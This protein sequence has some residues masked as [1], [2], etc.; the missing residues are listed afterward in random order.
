LVAALLALP[1]MSIGTT[2]VPIFPEGY[3]FAEGYEVWGPVNRIYNPGERQKKSAT[4][5]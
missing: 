3:K 4:R 5:F 2:L 1:D